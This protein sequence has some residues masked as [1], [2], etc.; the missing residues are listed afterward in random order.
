M[1]KEYQVT[2]D[3]CEQTGPETWAMSNYSLKVTDRTT[4][5]EIQDWIS[6]MYGPP[7]PDLKMDFRVVELQS[8]I[9]QT[10]QP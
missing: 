1:E 10:P 8:L 9:S 7:S 2:I 4:I 3:K 5:G 6:G